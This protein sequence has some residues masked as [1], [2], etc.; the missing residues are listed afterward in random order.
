MG[1]GGGGGDSQ[2]NIPCDGIFFMST[3]FTIIVFVRCIASGRN[4]YK[5]FKG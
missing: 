4:F 2:H 3:N 1:G 5:H